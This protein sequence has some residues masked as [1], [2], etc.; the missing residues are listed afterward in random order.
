MDLRPGAV[1]AALVL[2][3]LAPQGC[4]KRLPHGG[5]DPVYP[6]KGQH[7]TVPCEGCHETWPPVAQS[8]SCLDC[9]VTD[10]PDFDH[11]PGQ[12][13]F[14]CHTEDGWAVGVYPTG[15]TGT[16]TGTV[17]PPTGDTG[18]PPTTTTTVEEHR[19]MAPDVLCWTCHADE[20]PDDA[21]RW[22]H[23]NNIDIRIR[24]DCGPCHTLD[25]WDN[26]L[27]FDP[28]HLFRSPHGGYDQQFPTDTDEWAIACVDCHP[29]YPASLTKVVCYDCHQDLIVPHKGFDFDE[30]SDVQRCLGCHPTGDTYNPLSQ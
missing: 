22:D 30:N 25:A 12:E 17:D 24:Y 9:H 3:V 21:L 10:L 28:E 4:S 29:D 18:T 6:L 2:A 23:W 8:T 7:A 16:E 27:W 14:P 26:P 11:Y 19:N 15:E 20:R 5:D 13:C 1:G